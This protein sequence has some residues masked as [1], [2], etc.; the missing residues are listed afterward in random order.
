MQTVT[1][2]QLARSVVAAD[3]FNQQTTIAQIRHILEVALKSGLAL[4]ALASP[5]ALDLGNAHTMMCTV[6]LASN[7]KQLAVW[8]WLTGVPPEEVDMA[9][10]RLLSHHPDNDVAV[11]VLGVFDLELG[12]SIAGDW[13][14]ES[15]TDQVLDAITHWMPYDVPSTRLPEEAHLGKAAA[16]R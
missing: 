12:W 16:C 5:V 4:S 3:G 10:L 11:V 7:A 15:Y 2:D 9:W 6:N 13:K 8:P 1:I 14:G